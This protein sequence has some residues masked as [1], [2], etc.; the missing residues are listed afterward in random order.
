[1]PSLNEGDI[2]FDG[3]STLCR[4]LRQHKVNVQLVRFGGLSARCRITAPRPSL[5]TANP[6]GA[7]RVQHNVAGKLQQIA[8][9][10][11]QN[12]FE[13]PLKHMADAGLGADKALF[14]AIEANFRPNANRR[15]IRSPHSINEPE[16]AALLVKQFKEIIPQ[17]AIASR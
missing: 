9:F 2:V 1:M 4:E 13:A 11:N 6:L 10:V 17:P 12:G 8:V 3:A 7:Q 14:T 16:F 5:Q 15:L